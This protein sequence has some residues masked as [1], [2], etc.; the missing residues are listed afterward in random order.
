MS[1]QLPAPSGVTFNLLS[2][3]APLPLAPLDFAGAS[4]GATGPFSQGMTAGVSQNLNILASKIQTVT[5][6]GCGGFGVLNG[7][8]LTAGTGLVVNISAGSALVGDVLD[9]G[10]GSLVLPSS[11]ISYVWLTSTGVPAFSNLLAPPSGA[12]CFLGTVVTNG[13]AISSVD[14][15]NRIFLQDGMRVR[16]TADLFAPADQP[17]SRCRVLTWTLNGSYFWDGTRHVSFASSGYQQPYAA[18]QMTIASNLALTPQSSNLQWIIP[19][20]ASTVILPLVSDVPVGGWYKI[21][22]AGDPSLPAQDFAISVLPASG[23]PAIASL[24]PGQSALFTVQPSSSGSGPRW[25]SS[26]TV[27]T[28]A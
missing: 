22:N 28:G 6:G 15:S 23:Q 26:V 5:Q 11:Q 4:N 18:S 10:G 9:Y 16:Q 25:P 20:S 7:L 27:Q 12:V 19:Q 21:V 8:D 17:P 24:N 1:F 3:Q 2:T 13:S 14:Y